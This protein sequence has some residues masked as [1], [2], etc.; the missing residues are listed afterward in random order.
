MFNPVI[1]QATR[2][3]QADELSQ[4]ADNSN[5][6]QVLTDLAQEDGLPPEELSDKMGLCCSRPHT[7]DANIHTSVSLDLTTSSLSSGSSSASR[8]EPSQPLFRYRTAELSGANVDGICV[9][10]AAEWLLNLAG[11]PS[12]RMS[13]LAPGAENHAS[14]AVRQQRYEDLKALLR[15]DR[16]VESTNL[17]A[18]TAMLREAGLE[19]A[20]NQTQYEFGTSS[21]I[22]RIVNE[23]THYP[24]VH[25]ISLRFEPRGA[26]TIA[27]STSNGMTTLFDPNYG[28]FTVRSD[29]MGELFKSLVDRYRTPPNRLR[30]ST[31]VTQRMT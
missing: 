16:A 9:G 1:G 29:Q 28:E 17:Q 4:S 27:T 26:H 24:S 23:V 8:A 12:S 11:S 2:A 7:S 30:I 13:A 21:E 18:K 19:P 5:F 3:D 15:S 22:A 14:A 10:L 20:N 6:E 25:L 31:V